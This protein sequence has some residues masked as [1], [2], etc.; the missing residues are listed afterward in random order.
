MNK[1]NNKIM[2]INKKNE[3]ERDDYDLFSSSDECVYNNIKLMYN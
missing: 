3:N 2:S 1:I